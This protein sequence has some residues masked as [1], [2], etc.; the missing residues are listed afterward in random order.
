MP[1][2]DHKLTITEIGTLDP[3]K[4]VLT[5][6][7]RPNYMTFSQPFIDEEGEEAETNQRIES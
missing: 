1:E 5:N 2:F 6:L 3:S 7:L 4:D